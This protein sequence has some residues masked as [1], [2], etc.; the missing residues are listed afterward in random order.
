MT[1]RLIPSPEPSPKRKEAAEVSDWTPG[2]APEIV[3]AV[4]SAAKNQV[5]AG[6]VDSEP[7]LESEEAES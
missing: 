7:A 3:R 6:V 4:W 5:P 1:T 2:P